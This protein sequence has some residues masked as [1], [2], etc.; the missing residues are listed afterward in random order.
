MVQPYTEEDDGLYITADSKAFDPL[1]PS[2]NTI[3]VS[4]GFKF[5]ENLLIP[6]PVL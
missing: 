5:C 1:N 3:I 4:L 2:I 6:F